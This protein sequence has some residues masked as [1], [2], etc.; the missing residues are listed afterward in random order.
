MKSK[1]IKVEQGIL[2]EEAVNLNK[3]F[4]KR[5][6]EKK[7]FITI[8]VASSIDGNTSL[9][10]GE[11]KWITSDYARED[12]QKLRANVC[13]I[14]TGVGTVNHDNPNLNVRNREIAHAT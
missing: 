4:F 2:E 7:P 3:G 1:N 9:K 8:K 13:A 14:L 12:V 11:S 5:I 10:G 6:K